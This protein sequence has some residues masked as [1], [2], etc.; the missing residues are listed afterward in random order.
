MH[1]QF[2]SAVSVP[3]STTHA[4][5]QIGFSSAGVKSNHHVCVF[6]LY[7]YVSP[8]VPWSAQLLL[9][10]IT[11]ASSAVRSGVI[12]VGHADMSCTMV[13]SGHWYR[14]S[15]SPPLPGTVHPETAMTA[16]RTIEAKKS[17]HFSF[18]FIFMVYCCAMSLNPFHSLRIFLPDYARDV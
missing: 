17:S 13:P 2:I 6:A 11:F 7:V 5:L 18:S 12:P 1:L 4:G 14:V 3:S 16:T 9:S 10:A 8:T 15:A